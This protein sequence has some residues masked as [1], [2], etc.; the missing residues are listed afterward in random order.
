M[1]D[2][3]AFNVALW[4]SGTMM[5]SSITWRKCFLKG[6]EGEQK[7]AVKEGERN[8]GRERGREEREG[9]KEQIRISEYEYKLVT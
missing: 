5:L 6:R 4:D 1:S 3:K 2:G 7:M 9:K 8:E